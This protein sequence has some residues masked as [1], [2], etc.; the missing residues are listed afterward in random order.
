MSRNAVIHRVTALELKV[1]PFAWPFAKERRAEIDTHFAEKLREKPKI[2]NG[3][4]LLARN[5]DFDGGRLSSSYFETDFAS[6]LAWRDWGFPDAGVFNGFGMGALR[7]ADG[8]FVLGEMAG[9]T[10]NAGRIYFPAG[11][12]DPEDVSDGRLDIAGS[13]AR[14]L[15]EETGLTPADYRTCAHWDCVV[16][17]A[18]V[19]IMRILTV[20]MP[21]EAL[22][23]RIEANLAQQTHP[24][25]SAIHLVR[26]ADDFSSHMPRFI[27]TYLEH[28]LNGGSS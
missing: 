12:P 22:K 27:T 4:V 21:A 9:H 11:T 16:V 5:A 6:M 2:W 24:E 19:A 7:S 18:S 8:A 13:V 1:E 20:D 10:A 15:E 28:V 3:R 17:G 26:S 25:L 23:T 14:E